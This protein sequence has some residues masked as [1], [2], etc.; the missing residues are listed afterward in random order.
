M[1][2]FKDFLAEGNPL[3]RIQKFEQEGRHYS[4]ISAERSGLSAQENHKRMNELK[5]IL[6]AKGYGYRKAKGMWQG[7]EENSFVVHAKA[8]GTLAG[9]SLRQDMIAI[10]KRYDQDSVLHHDG[11]HGV[12]HGT[13]KTGW[14]GYGKVERVGK[15]HYNRPKQPN[16]TAFHPTR[17]DKD[18]PKITMADKLNP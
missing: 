8:P 4:A 6:K 17:P 11:D 12:L 2:T 16:Q 18:R 14:P 1:L 15:T 7:G 10:G 3:A 13:N 9:E 5:G